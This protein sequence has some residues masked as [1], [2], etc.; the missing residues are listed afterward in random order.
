MLIGEVLEDP[1]VYKTCQSLCLKGAEVTIACTN[2]SGRSVREIHDFNSSEIVNSGLVQSKSKT[3]FEIIRFPHRKEFILK[4]LYN[5]FQG[6]INPGV[7]RAAANLHETVPSSPL[8]EFIR[9]TMIM[10]NFRQYIKSSRQIN[11]K[12]IHAFS[13]HT[14]DLVHCN[15]VDTLYAGNDFK[16]S[17]VAREMLYDAHEYWPGVGLHGSPANKALGSIEA[18]GIKNADYVITVNDI[19]A[20]M[21]REMHG[22]H[23]KPAVVMNCPRKYK[24][25]LTTDSVHVPV[26]LLYQ[27]KV[28]AFRGLEQLVLACKF[29][30]GAELT[31][32][33]YGPIT[34]RL[35]LL[36][37]S[38]GL[39]ERVRFTGKY[40]PDEALSII[41]KHDIGVLPLDPATL[42]IVYSS[43]NKLF[44][45]AMGGL[46]IAANDLPF[47]RQAVVENNMGRIYSRNDPEMIAETINSMIADTHRLKQYKCNARK[48]AE[49][50]YYWEKQFENYP[51]N[52]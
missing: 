26:R 27:G 50:S 49:D 20:D 46:A 16:E 25:S 19:I 43:P 5:F 12:M 52:L 2:P 31:I 17:G 36:A 24:G 11:R 8:K 6:R 34:E 1:R 45:Y 51:W 48:A 21:I 22:L 30:N 40:R 41:T 38:E 29:I 23:T 28:Q 18:E 42:S 7:G 13:G 39:S 15:D 47:I 9:N 37:E 4:R 10:M 3:Q 44:D 33:G 35:A 14:F 32:S